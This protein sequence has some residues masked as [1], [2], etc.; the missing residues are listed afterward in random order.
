V[1]KRK[2]ERIKLL[3]KLAGQYEQLAARD[4]GRSTSNLL[5]QM[6]R[7]EQL[8]KFRLE[9]T[10]QFRAAGQQGMDA[11]SMMAFQ[12]FLKQ[13]DTAIAQQQQTV[14]AAHGDKQQKKTHWENKHIT[15]NVY[16]KTLQRTLKK[17]Q[18]QEDRKLQNA[19][20]EHAQHMKSTDKS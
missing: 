12:N 11:R 17:E 7:L 14:D 18:K 15:T 9:Y 13:L 20:D 19:A 8:K 2:S 5:E 4:L 6:E 10:H 16:D 3:Q 1:V